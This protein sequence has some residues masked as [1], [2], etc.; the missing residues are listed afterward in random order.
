MI[1]EAP[2][3]TIGGTEVGAGNVISGN[4]GISLNPTDIGLVILGPVATGNVVQGNFIGTDATGTQSL[5][6]NGDGLDIQMRP[7]TRLVGRSPAPG[8][9]ISGNRSDGVRIVSTSQ[10]TATGN[11]VEGNYIGTDA[12]GATPGQRRQRRGHHRR[13]EQH[14]RR[15]D[16]R[17]PQRHLGQR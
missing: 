3:N 1:I 14:D 10:G 15:D 7:A 12:S 5:G 13:V 9:V 6:N 16:R 17:R 8:N 11:V 4:G 2:R